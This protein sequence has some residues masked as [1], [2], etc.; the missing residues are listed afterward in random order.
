M[1]FADAGAGSGRVT[2]RTR[3][4]AGALP[5]PGRP[6][7]SAAIL[8]RMQPVVRLVLVLVLVLVLGLLAS[9]SMVA[10]RL[11]GRAR[12]ID[13][14]TIVVGGVHVRLQGVA[15]PEV[16]HPGQ[17]QDE[18]GGPEAKAFIQELVEDR[19]VV[20]TLT[21]ERTLGRRVGTCMVDG[22]DISAGS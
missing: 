10:E 6:A 11:V 17:P 14:A 16:A 12:V 19:T 21:G 8:S 18:P 20:C 9:S 2:G 4:A 3:S 5:S 1:A 7:A 15:A 13:G 22:H